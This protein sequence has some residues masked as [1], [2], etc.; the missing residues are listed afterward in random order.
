M[1]PVCP[2]DRL[3][4]AA[5]PDADTASRINRFAWRQRQWHGLKGRPMD[6]HLL[7]VTLW[8]VG[9]DVRAP[10]PRLVEE[11][12]RRL[13]SI[14]MPPFRVSFDRLM[15]FRNGALVL[16]G[17]DG[18]AGLEMLHEHLKAAMVVDGTRRTPAFTPHM[19]LLRDRRHVLA[20]EVEPTVDWTV[21]ELVLVHSLLGRTTQRHVA[22]L[23]L[24]SPPPS[25]RGSSTCR[26]CARP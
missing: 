20:D 2:T 4:V 24:A 3:F 11:L 6:A 10:P 17:G 14:E 16:C 7:H 22:R 26:R 23:P 12:V 13:A 1:E 5:I 18:V 8:L 15:S 19:T 9:D 21:S 25:G